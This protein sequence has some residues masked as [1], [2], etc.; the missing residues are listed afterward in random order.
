MACK[1][2]RDGIEHAQVT[3][4]NPSNLEAGEGVQGVPSDRCG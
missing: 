2:P 1:G 4:L 3:Q